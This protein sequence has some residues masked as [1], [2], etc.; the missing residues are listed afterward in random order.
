[1]VRV[2]VDFGY[3]VHTI[4]IAKGTFAQIQTGKLLTLQGQGFPVEGLIEPDHWA[5]NHGALGAVHVFTDSGRDVFEGGFGDAEV[6][7]HRD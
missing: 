1:M 4:S 3:D 7:V 6:A 5:F 2:S